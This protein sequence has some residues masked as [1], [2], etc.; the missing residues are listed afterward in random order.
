MIAT[1]SGGNQQKVVLA[2]WLRQDPQ[3]LIL[4]EPTQG[5]D[6]GA[7]ADIHALVDGCADAGAAVLVASTESEELARL[8]DRVL[9]LRAGRVVAELSGAQVSASRITAATRDSGFVLA[10]TE[11]ND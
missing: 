5:V 6:V 7:K 10:G 8:C 4:D 2:R 3:V 11:P 9:V 1:L